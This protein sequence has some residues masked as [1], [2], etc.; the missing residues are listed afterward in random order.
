MTSY[1]SQLITG[2][3]ARTCSGTLPLDL[4]NEC[5]HLFLKLLTRLTLVCFFVEVWPRG[6]Y[7]PWYYFSLPLSSP[8]LHIVIFLVDRVKMGWDGSPCNSFGK[9]KIVVLYNFRFEGQKYTRIRLP[10]FGKVRRGRFQKIVLLF[11][12]C[13]FL[14]SGIIIKSMTDNVMEPTSRKESNKMEN[15]YKTTEKWRDVFQCRVNVQ[16]SSTVT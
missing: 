5:R 15:F 2:M 11:V 3:T 13:L 7:C 12:F 1:D 6:E 9:M 16:K 10:E 4:V 8:S 14:S